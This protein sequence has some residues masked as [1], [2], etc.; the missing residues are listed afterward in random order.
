MKKSII[1][2]GSIALLSTT[3]LSSCSSDQNT[4][5]E[6]ASELKT[7]IVE[8]K[9]EV[10]DEIWT[11][12]KDEIQGRIDANKDR[13]SNLRD[14]KRDANSKLSKEEYKAKIDELQDRNQRLR[15][16][17]AEYPMNRTDWEEF[18]AGV[19]EEVGSIGRSLDEI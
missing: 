4:E 1:L 12:Y 17:L 5:K 13:I 18:K 16:K 14:A 2:F 7:E 10:S 11:A 6:T 3:M 9:N 8:T 19:N 15:E